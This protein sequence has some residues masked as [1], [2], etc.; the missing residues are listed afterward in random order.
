MTERL[1]ALAAWL[2]GLLYK[3]KFTCAVCGAELYE[4]AYFCARCRAQLPYNTGCV[5]S[6]C[7]R[8][9]AEEAPVC[10][11]CKAHMPSYDRAR[12]AF[13]YEGALVPLI[14]KFKTGG[15]H[16]AAAL[17]DAMLPVLQREFAD[18]D[19]LVGVPMTRRARR[20]RGYDQS[21]L[22][23]EA[24]S[25]RSGIPLEA[26]LLVKTRET[27]AQKKLSRRERA[28]NLK[29]SFRVHERVKCRGKRILVIDDVLTTGATASAVAETLLRAGAARVCVLTAASVPYA[30]LRGGGEKA[31]F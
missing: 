23:A 6:K 18:A 30:L 11:E 28:E 4:D 29:G 27:A 20:R 31:V 7:G 10:L 26:S 24:L 22:L 16:L 14:K 1:R 19:L 5:C 3:E 25:A 12:S 15:R 17:A 2:K 8:A 21:R 9:V 13:C